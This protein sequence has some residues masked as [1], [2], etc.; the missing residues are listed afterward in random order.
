MKYIAIVTIESEDELD[1]VGKDLHE[2][3]DDVFSNVVVSAKLLACQNEEQHMIK[4]GFPYD[5]KALRERG[6]RRMPIQGVYPTEAVR[7]ILARN[8]VVMFAAIVAV[9]VVVAVVAYILH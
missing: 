4:D 8:A 3:L 9:L 1:Q 6:A 2:V 5:K 7:N